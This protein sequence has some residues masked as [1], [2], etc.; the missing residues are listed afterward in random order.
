MLDATPSRS[1]KIPTTPCIGTVQYNVTGTILC[2][3]SEELMG[4]YRFEPSGR[5]KRTFCCPTMVHAISEAPAWVWYQSV[6]RPSGC[7][8][9]ERWSSS[10]TPRAAEQTDLHFHLMPSNVQGISANS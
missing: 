2:N 8:R 5:L 9:K 6:L 3:A 1:S 7:G 4:G 10:P